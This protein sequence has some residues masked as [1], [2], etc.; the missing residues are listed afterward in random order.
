MKKI[1]ILLFI[2]IS[3]LHLFFEWNGE[4]TKLYFSKPLLMPVLA[5]W[6]WWSLRKPRQLKTFDYTILAALFFSCLG[7]ILLLPD[8]EGSAISFEAGLGSFL[9]AHLFY[10][11]SFVIYPPKKWIVKISIALLFFGVGIAL[12][13]YL[14]SD[15]P[16]SLIVPIL[17]YAFTICLMGIT[18]YG[19][20]E[21]V[22]TS[23]GML[24]VYGALIFILSDSLIAINKFKLGQQ[25][26]M[27]RLS[28]MI[29]YLLAQYLI[30]W[31]AIKASNGL[32]KQ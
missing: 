27:P 9:L 22:G 14:W 31:G 24:I 11:R 13:F 32:K 19:M 16:S 6:Y 20:L 28:I 8:K 2:G 18:A 10:I 25:I 4:Q 15:I 29:T 26:W 7:D 21:K 17:L 1:G 3:I 23:I 30:V 12:I 5:A